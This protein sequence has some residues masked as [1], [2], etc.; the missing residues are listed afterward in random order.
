ML[1]KTNSVC[2]KSSKNNQTEDPILTILLFI[3]VLQ[4]LAVLRCCELF[5]SGKLNIN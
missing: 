3:R 2:A 4:G 5:V 1:Q